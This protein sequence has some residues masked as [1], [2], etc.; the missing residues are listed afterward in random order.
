ML[1]ALPSRVTPLPKIRAVD[2]ALTCC[3]AGVGKDNATEGPSQAIYRCVYLAAVTASLIADPL[4]LISSLSQVAQLRSW[5]VAARKMVFES[6]A[7]QSGDSPSFIWS[8]QNAALCSREITRYFLAHVR[9]CFERCSLTVNFHDASSIWK[10]S[11][12]ID[13]IRYFGFDTLF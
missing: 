2:S 4:G 8:Q 1:R 11:S 7:G 13:L 10:Y 3:S 6:C 5:P 9:S 12:R